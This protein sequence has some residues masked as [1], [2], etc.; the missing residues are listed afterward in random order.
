MERSHAMHLTQKLILA[1]AAML[2]A[3]T[4][5]ADG[6]GTFSGQSIGPVAELTPDERA[7]FRE[8]WRE[9]PPEQREAVRDRLRQNWQNLPPEERQKRR[10]ELIEHAHESGNEPPPR[11][12]HKR[13]EGFGQG[14]GTR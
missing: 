9:M 14:Y 1:T 4:A 8:R 3:G 10:Q 12:R 13:D 11:D 2:A 7:R 6:P 5:M